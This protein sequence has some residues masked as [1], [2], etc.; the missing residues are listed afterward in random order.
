MDWD[1]FF[2]STGS[3]QMYLL[4]I[5]LNLILQSSLYSESIAE[6]AYF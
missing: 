2:F 4:E 3:I 1:I 6:I 5:M